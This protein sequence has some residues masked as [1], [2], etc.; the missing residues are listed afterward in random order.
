MSKETEALVRQES[1]AIG[2][3]P[4]TGTKAIVLE[5]P[6]MDK[7]NDFRVKPPPP[8][9]GCGG[10]AHGPVNQALACVVFHMRTARSV[11]GVSAPIQCK[12]CGQA[13]RSADQHIACLEAALG[14]SRA[15][16]GVGVSPEQFRLNQAQS[17]H[18]EDTRGKNKKG[19][20]G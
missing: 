17:R 13:H 14:T 9:E 7:T 2:A 1:E 5:A 6:V 3:V 11:A 10:P 12:G 8:C 19:G 4:N 20:G 18:F 15:R 16:E